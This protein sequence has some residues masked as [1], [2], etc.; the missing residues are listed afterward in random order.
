MVL[1]IIILFGNNGGLGKLFLDI[2]EV[3]GKVVIFLKIK[4]FFLK[5]YNDNV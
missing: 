5:K 1:V 2:G 4:D 3:F